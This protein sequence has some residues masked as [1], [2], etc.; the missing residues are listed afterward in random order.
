MIKFRLYSSDSFE[1]GKMTE[2]INKLSSVALGNFIFKEVDDRTIECIVSDDIN[3]FKL[4]IL[5]LNDENIWEVTRVK[6]SLH[7]LPEPTKSYSIAL[8]ELID[9]LEGKGYSEG[10]DFINR[11]SKGKNDKV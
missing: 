7:P 8:C 2:M 6:L 9:S 11:L 3:E 5:S 4:R 10:I 1:E